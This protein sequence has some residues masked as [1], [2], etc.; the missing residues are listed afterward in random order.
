MLG[1]LLGPFPYVFIKLSQLEVM[2][3]FKV[4]TK[5][6]RSFS[7]MFKCYKD[8]MKKFVTVVGPFQIKSILD[9]SIV[10]LANRRNKLDYSCIWITLI[11]GWLFLIILASNQ[12]SCSNS[13]Y[14]SNQINF[15]Y[16]WL[17]CSNSWLF[18]YLN[19]RRFFLV[20]NCSGLESIRALPL[21]SFWNI[22]SQLMLL[23]EC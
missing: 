5:I 12:N 13:D 3:K 18:L 9:G 7:N 16:S 20:S 17:H 19:L 14:S 11:L 22:S 23:F 10:S 4:Q 15:D 8:C 21:R 1:V 6:K 2:V